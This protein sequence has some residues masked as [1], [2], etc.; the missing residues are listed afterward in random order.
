MITNTIKE[1]FGKKNNLCSLFVG[2][3]DSLGIID[4]EAH[5]VKLLGLTQNNNYIL[6]AFALSD[7]LTSE[8]FLKKKKDIMEKLGVDNL[9]IFSKNTYMYFKI[10][11]NNP[12]PIPYE[13]KLKK[14]PWLIPIGYDEDFNVVY[15]NIRIDPHLLI[16]GATASGKTVCLH[17]LINYITRSTYHDLFLSD[18]K[19]GVD[20]NVYGLHGLNSVKLY[21]NTKHKT[22]EMIQAFYIEMK[23]RLDALSKSK[24]NN[25]DE[26]CDKSGRQPFKRLFMI[27]DEF[28]DLVPLKK[29]KDDVDYIAVLVDLA[30]KCRAVGMHIIISAQRPEATIVKGSLKS[31]F[32]ARLGFRMGSALDS[33]IIIDKVGC[34]HL[35]QGQCIARFA[36]K[37][38]LVRTAI[39][40]E[41]DINQLLDDCSVNILGDIIDAEYKEHDVTPDSPLLL[42]HDIDISDIFKDETGGLL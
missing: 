10:R 38:T 15:W 28:P 17:G 1:L 18:M 14:E 20:F 26:W 27:I 29:K 4:T 23:D 21:A 35:K 30:R 36:G 31:N 16:G 42:E 32:T 24:Y 3:F 11:K 2:I 8:S 40:K 39:V 33:R 6:L 12:P 37:E 7:N 19:S 22:E 9:E 41:K 34:E 25:Y 13:F 5:H